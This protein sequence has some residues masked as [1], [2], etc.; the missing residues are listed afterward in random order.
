MDQQMDDDSYGALDSWEEWFLRFLSYPR[1]EK[2]RRVVPRRYITSQGYNLGLWQEKQRLA[3]KRYSPN[4]TKERVAMMEEAGMVWDL[5]DE[6]WEN[7]FAHFEAVPAD[8]NGKR[9]LNASYRTADGYRLGSWQMQQRQ[10]YKKG[11]LSEERTKRLEAAGII[12]DQNM[13]KWEDGFSKF[14]KYPPNPRGFRL[15]PENFV[16]EEG[17]K[18]GVWQH[19]QRQAYKKDVLSNT[20]ITRLKLAGIVW[21]LQ[22][23]R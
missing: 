8:S 3:K 17:F 22:D 19:T 1:D 9:I 6:A 14:K 16:T 7:A 23:A 4:L 20:R 15:V 10:Y 5:H 18:L 2:G 11:V 21:D 13:Q 12:W